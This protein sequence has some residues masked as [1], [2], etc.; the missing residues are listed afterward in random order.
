MELLFIL[1]LIWLKNDSKANKCSVLHLETRCTLLFIRTGLTVNIISVR[2]PPLFV[3]HS[4]KSM[5]RLIK[6][7]F[8]L[9][10]VPQI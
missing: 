6:E 4:S 7:K 8:P 10:L 1:I 5:F 3:Y 9:A 2:P